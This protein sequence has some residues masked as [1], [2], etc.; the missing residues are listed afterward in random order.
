MCPIFIVEYSDLARKGCR[1][2]RNIFV[3]V[4]IKRIAFY[5]FASG[6]ILV[7]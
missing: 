6:I 4:L 7:Y 1:G 3:Q 2:V 5:T